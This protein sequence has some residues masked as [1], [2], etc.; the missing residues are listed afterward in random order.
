VQPRVLAL[1]TNDREDTADP[2]DASMFSTFQAKRRR[3]GF[4]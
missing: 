1:G 2:A 3:F 4:F